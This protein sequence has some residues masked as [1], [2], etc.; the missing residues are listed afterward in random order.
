M[1]DTIHNLRKRIGVNRNI[2]KVIEA[3]RME[4]LIPKCKIRNLLVE[5]MAFDLGLEE[6][7]KFQGMWL[8]FRI[9]KGAFQ[10]K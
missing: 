4:R 9:G 10:V 6:W 8:R 1:V 3:H 7:S 5:K 2:S